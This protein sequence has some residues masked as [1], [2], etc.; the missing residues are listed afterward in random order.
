[1]QLDKV[2]DK[3]RKFQPQWLFIAFQ[4]FKFAF[5]S[6][7]WSLVENLQI[8]HVEKTYHQQLIWHLVY[9]AMEDPQCYFSSR[10]Y[11][12]IQGFYYLESDLPSLL[13]I[14]SVNQ[15]IPPSK[16]RFPTFE[17]DMA[18]SCK[19]ARWIIWYA[20]VENKLHEFIP[21]PQFGAVTTK[22][23]WHRLSGALHIHDTCNKILVISALGESFSM[24]WS[25]MLVRD[26]LGNVFLDLVSHSL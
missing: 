21:S 18:H 9:K 7:S 8:D 22:R 6:T 12:V 3:V 14:V 13:A 1:M 24:L 25:L 17:T 10:F 19:E 4:I 2:K 15:N 11:D 16:N 23:M 20:Y 5:Y 26:F